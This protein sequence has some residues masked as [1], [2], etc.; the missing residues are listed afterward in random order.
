MDKNCLP[1]ETRT[2]MTKSGAAGELT[3]ILDFQVR[4]IE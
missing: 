1:A 4:K 2:T 3:S